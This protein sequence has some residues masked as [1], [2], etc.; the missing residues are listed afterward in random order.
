MSNKEG[1]ILGRFEPLRGKGSKLGE[2]SFS[3]VYKAIDRETGTEVAVKTY[4]TTQ[5]QSEEGGL[6]PRTLV[7]KNSL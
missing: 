4:K 1:L 7:L 6:I 3:S 2:G 5:N